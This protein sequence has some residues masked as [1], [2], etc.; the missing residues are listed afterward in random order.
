MDPSVWGPTLWA[1]A[2]AVAENAPREETLI[3]LRG[4]RRFLPCEACRSSYIHIDRQFRPQDDSLDLVQWVW[5]L[6]DLVN[7]K[8]RKH[9]LPISR[10]EQRRA[11]FPSGTLSPLAVFD[12]VLL[13]FYHAEHRAPNRDETMRA[14][15]ESLPAIAHAL[16]PPT[17]QRH[18]DPGR[19]GLAKEPWREVLE[20]KNR[21]LRQWGAPPV[22]DEEAKAQVRAAEAVDVVTEAQGQQSRFGTVAPPTGRR[23]RRWRVQGGGL[24][25]PY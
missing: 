23:S 24:N 10:F 21:L 12:L 20:S 11:A 18:F 6:H 16:Q 22:T 25:F 4:M 13:L 17:L 19:I 15:R 9:T 7:Q 14:L 8:L 1:V 5:A 3:F 2:H